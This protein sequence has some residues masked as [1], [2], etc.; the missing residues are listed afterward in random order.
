[1]KNRQIEDEDIDDIQDD[2]FEDKQPARIPRR[3]R[4]E[5]PEPTMQLTSAQ[6]QVG[7]IT[8][9]LIL[10]SII[11][12]AFMDLSLGLVEW[13]IF[14][15]IL[16]LVIT[17]TTLLVFKSMRNF[18]LNIASMAITIGML[19]TFIGIYNGLIN[20]DSMQLETSVPALIDGMK[21]AFFTSITG[22]IASVYIRFVD[23]IVNN[24]QE[25]KSTTE[26]EEMLSNFKQ[27]KE[28]S[29]KQSKYLHYS[30]E[31][32]RVMVENIVQL[33]TTLLENQKRYDHIMEMTGEKLAEAIG[34][35]I[36][37]RLAKDLAE[38]VNIA[39]KPH[40]EHIITIVTS[41]NTIID[42]LNHDLNDRLSDLNKTITG[43]DENLTEKLSDFT[44][45]L[46]MTTEDMSKTSTDAIIKG[47]T[48]V[49]DEFNDGLTV[50]LGDNFRHLKT[51]VDGLSKWQEDYKSLIDKNYTDLSKVFD[52]VGRCTSSLEKTSDYYNELAENSNVLLQT[53]KTIGE[54]LIQLNDSHKNIQTAFTTIN[55]IGEKAADAIRPM[56]E[57]FEQINAT[58][59][60]FEVFLTDIAKVNTKANKQMMSTIQDTY[61][62]MDDTFALM[63][64]QL[65]ER[66]E[67][68]TD[69]IESINDKIEDNLEQTSRSFD[70]QQAKMDQVI[71]DTSKSLTKQLTSVSK[72]YVRDYTE[73]T[74]K[75]QDMISMLPEMVE[76]LNRVPRS[77]RGYDDEDG[78]A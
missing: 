11:G 36:T 67:Q 49:I 76:Q 3:T 66:E 28:E 1:M 10:L 74:K 6:Q 17:A 45:D 12:V 42:D 22:M 25:P 54:T 34:N 63:Q 46:R 44:R 7:G 8:A 47:V 62:D 51:S 33:N 15:I 32:S 61:K 70:R 77:R 37:D 56:T 52:E 78:V 2:D 71:T 48:T 9:V 43:L 39:L 55:S 21:T 41:L 58:S 65:Q 19:G 40:H 68:L 50:Q 27:L 73:I 60:K 53:S 20:F 29:V 24:G 4:K 75:L 23:V 69:M 30:S 59:A 64:R 72:T 5:L 18:A 38:S 14:A 31:V 35:Q 57:Y 26:K 13:G 16:A